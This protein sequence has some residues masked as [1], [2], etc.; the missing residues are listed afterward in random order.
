MVVGGGSG[1]RGEWDGRWNHINTFLERPGPYAYHDFEPSTELLQFFLDICKILVIGA[2]GL[3]CELLK[4][5][6]FSG[7]RHI[8]VVDMDT[9]DV[10]NLNRQIFFRLKDVGRPK[11]DIAADFINS[12]IPGCNVLPHFKKIE[13]FDEPFY[14]QFHIIVCGLDSIITRRWMNGML[15]SLLV[16]KDGVLDSSSI[17]PLIDRRTE[18]FKGN[19]WVVFPG[20]TACIYCTLE[21]YPSQIN[22]PMCTIASMPR[23]PE[24]CV[25]YVLRPSS[26]FTAAAQPP[27]PGPSPGPSACVWLVRWPLLVAALWLQPP[28]YPVPRSSLSSAAAALRSPVLRRSSSSAAVALRS[29]VLVSSADT[30]PGVNM[31]P[32]PPLGVLQA[33]TVE[34][35]LL[36]VPGQRGQPPSDPPPH[37]VGSPLPELPHSL[38]WP[39]QRQSPWSGELKHLCDGAARC[40]KRQAFCWTSRP[41][42]LHFCLS[43]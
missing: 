28:K 27:D 24:H 8:Y 15:L 21:L 35:L 3:G 18:G 6:A 12:R 13:D 16:Y 25:E 26:S 32:A 9:I 31:T 7:F 41:S 33:L 22:F 2:G 4:D 19:A 23:L 40:I 37:L 5:L 34:V 14:R 42:G 10:S 20:M 38:H 39:P 43:R 1:D 29:P 11:A 17:I 30:V 36:P